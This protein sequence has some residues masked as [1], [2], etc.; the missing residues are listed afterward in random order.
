M[1]PAAS[2]DISAA[3]FGNGKWI[4]VVL[5]LDSWAGL[6]CAQELAIRIGTTSD[7]VAGVLRRMKAAQMIK[8]HP[9]V[10]SATRGTI[11]WE[12]QRGPDWDATV[13]LCKELTQWRPGAGFALR[14]RQTAATQQ[15]RPQG[16]T[17]TA[18]P[19]PKRKASL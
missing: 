13:A 8:D 4:E 19:S 1:T 18:L 9:R 15:H 11:H 3:V 14:G 17:A 12:V 5:L 7:L 6:P 16:V 10:G 2:R